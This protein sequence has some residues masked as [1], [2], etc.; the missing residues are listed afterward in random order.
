MPPNLSGL[1][2]FGEKIWVHNPDGSKLDPRVREGQWIGFN[3]ESRGHCMYWSSS[4]SVGVK[5]NVDFAAAERLKGEKLDVPTSKTLLTEPHAALLLL[6]APLPPVPV[7]APPSPPSPL[8]SLS[9]V[10]AM[11]PEPQPEHLTRLCKPSQI[12]RELQAD[13]GIASTR[14]SDPTIPRGVSVPGSF[15]KDEETADVAVEAWSV[16]AGLPTPHESWLGLEV[17]LAAKIADSEALELRNLAEAKHRPD[18]HLW[19]QAIHKELTTLHAAGTWT[20]K[21]TPPGANVIGSKWVFK[22]KK[23]T[24]GKVVHYKARLVVQ[25]FSQVEGV[26]YFNT[27]APVARLVSSCTVITMANCLGLELH[28]VDIKGA[29][30]NG[31]LMADEVLYMRHPPGYREDASGHV[32]RLCKSLYR[33]KQAS[34]RWYQKFTSILSTLGFQQCKVDQAV[35]FKHCKAPRIFIVIAVHVDDCMITA[36]SVAAVN[37]FKARLRKHVEVMDLSELHW[38]LGIEVRRDHAGGTVHLSQ[39][40]YID[41]ILRRYSFNNVKPVSTPFNTQVRL[42]LEQAPADAA[43]F[44]VMRDMP[45][46]KAVGVLNWAALA[47]HPDIAFAVATVA[48]FSANPGMAHWV[49]VK[50]IFCYL[51]GTHD[52]WLMYGETCRTLVGYADADGSMT[53]D[54]HAITGYAFLIDGRAVSWSLK[55]QEI[56]SLSTTESEYIAATHGMKEALWLCNLLA[57]AFEPIADA[58]TLFSNNQSAIALTRDHQFHPRTKHI[59]VRYHF[60]HWVVENGVLRLV[61]CLTVD[62]VVDALTK[63]LPSP[64]VKHFAKCLGLCAV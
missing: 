1:K 15:G 3:I 26:D 13:V 42:T 49:A 24:S 2:C 53:E 40:S 41:S 16:E 58:T 37:A 17:A 61:Y 8:S 7:P 4:R 50:R 6:P 45:Y 47:T 11:L 5:Q 64:K 14:R 39:R 48:R 22:A 54:C 27:Y 12:V 44:A 33:L 29:Y 10:E 32:L 51:M 34:R 19:E 30:L 63:A 35:F 55:K 20:L 60:I 21:H 36:S 38:M 9:E 46:H 31:K 56:V 28:Q 43:E 52:L 57:K 59:D 25:G 23:D 62:M 18:W